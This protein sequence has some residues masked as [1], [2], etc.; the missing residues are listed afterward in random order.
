VVTVLVL[1]QAIAALSD[2][3]SHLEME[4]ETRGIERGRLARHIPADAPRG[5]TA[6]T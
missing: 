6:L 5:G 1:A 2:Q 4:N 3:L